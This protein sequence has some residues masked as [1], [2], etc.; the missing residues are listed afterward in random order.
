ML[1][2]A[3]TGAAAVAQMVMGTG[4]L[5]KNSI[6]AGAVIILVLISAIPLLKL[7]ILCLFYQGRQHF[8]SR[9][10]IKNGGLHQ[11]RWKWLPSAA[12]D[13]RC[14][15]LLFGVSLALYVRRPTP[16]ILQVK[17]GRE[18]E[19]IYRWVSNIV[20]YCICDNYYKSSAGWKV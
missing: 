18:M 20:Y 11:R 2:R 7:V 5:I 12:F 13:G 3:G 8:C 15:T 17:G 9:S 4:V 10:V 14:R 6:G 16:P 1:S 19:G